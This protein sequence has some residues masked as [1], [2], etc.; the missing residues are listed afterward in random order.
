MSAPGEAA[1]GSAAGEAAGGSGPSGRAAVLAGVERRLDPVAPE[2]T[3]GVA[4]LGYG[5]ISVGLRVAELP[6]R[7]CKRLS[8]FA[9]AADADAFVRVLGTYLD[10]LRA[11]GVDVVDTDVVPVPRAGQPPVVYLVQP[12]LTAAR[13][14]HMRL[15]EADDDELRGVLRRVLGVV[16]GLAAAERARTD[17]VEVALDGQLSNWWLPEDGAPPRLVDV[18]TPF[19]RRDGRYAMDLELLHRPIPPG[20]RAYY[21]WRGEVAAYM[22]DYFDPRLVAVDLLGNFHKEGRPDRVPLGVDVV[23]AWLDEEGS[24]FG[25][26]APVTEAEVREYY[27]KDAGLLAL[28]LRLRRADRLLRSRVL[29]RRYDYVLPGPIRR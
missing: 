8:G 3:D 19:L 11:G 7:V 14:A 29:R 2:R 23:N 21:R 27:R 16:G 13:F 25:P 4:V 20:I 28:Y 24:V 10:E 12:E 18:G 6:G 26:Q 15:R 17:G 5:E 22:D 9:D 1:G